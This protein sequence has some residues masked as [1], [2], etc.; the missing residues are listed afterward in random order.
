VL[1][2]LVAGVFF[3]A[4][5]ATRGGGGLRE[6]WSCECRAEAANGATPN[7]ETKH[8]TA[9]SAQGILKAAKA[10]ACQMAK[11]KCMAKWLMAN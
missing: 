5:V 2:L 8:Q 3:N 7:T 6:S 11:A 4:T 9:C 1:N 10:A